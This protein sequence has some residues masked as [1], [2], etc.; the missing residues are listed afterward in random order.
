MMFGDRAPAELI[1]AVADAMRQ[2][3]IDRVFLV[4]EPP[5]I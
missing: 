3:G 2:N 1:E 4:R 5:G